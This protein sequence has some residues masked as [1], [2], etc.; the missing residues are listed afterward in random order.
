MIYAHLILQLVLVLPVPDLLLHLPGEARL[1]AMELQVRRR[2][3][4]AGAAAERR[5]AGHPDSREVLDVDVFF[6]NLIVEVDE[7]GKILTFSVG[8]RFS[9]SQ[10]RK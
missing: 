10:A 9:L 4:A 5:P 7:A 3:S 1:L 2:L 8:S 6:E